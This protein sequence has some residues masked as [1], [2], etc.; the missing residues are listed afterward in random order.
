MRGCAREAGVEDVNGRAVEGRLETS[1]SWRLGIHEKDA[2][3]DLVCVAPRYCGL[4]SFFGAFADTL[5]AKK[6][7]TNFQ[8]IPGAFVPIMTFD[9]REVNIDLLLAVLPHL[10]TV[11]RTLDILDDGL[12]SDMDEKSRRSL[13]GPR[14]TLTVEKLVRTA[15]SHLLHPPDGDRRYGH[16]LRTVRVVRLWAKRRGIYSNKMGYLGGVNFNIM[17]TMVVQMYPHKVPPP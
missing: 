6:E 7:V 8:A 17:C 13:N 10:N 9:L 11:P 2:D 16:F 12:L 5:K 3:I 14:D 15:G 4:E 1:G